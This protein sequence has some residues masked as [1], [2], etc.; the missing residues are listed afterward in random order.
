M[1]Q[2]D[3]L[4]LPGG[5]T[6]MNG[7]LLVLSED[8]FDT[9]RCAVVA[10]REAARQ[11]GDGSVF[12]SMTS[13]SDAAVRAAKDAGEAAEEAASVAHLVGRSFAVLEAGAYWG[14]YNT[15]RAPPYLRQLAPSAR[16]GATSR[17]VTSAEASVR[18]GLDGATTGYD[19]RP[20][21]NETSQASAFRIADVRRE[22]PAEGP[23]SGSSLDTWQR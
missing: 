2:A 13:Q 18:G 15:D 12:V 19:I 10:R 4:D 11:L 17:L 14:A 5:K 23:E 1:T 3:E 6:L 8:A 20:I 21:L 16:R 7:S 22:W 9:C